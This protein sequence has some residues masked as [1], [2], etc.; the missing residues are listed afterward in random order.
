MGTT[1]T[2]YNGETTTVQDPASKSR[3]L[4]VD[5][6]G[7]ITSANAGSLSSAT[8]TYDSLGNAG[9]VTP[10]SQV[11]TFTYSSLSRLVSS[12]QPENGTTGYTFDDN[13]N[14]LKRTNGALKVFEFKPPTGAPF[15]KAY[16]GLNR[17]RRKTIQQPVGSDVDITWTWDT[18]ASNGKGQLASVVYGDTTISYGAYDSLGRVTSHTQTTAGIGY[19]FVYEYIR[20]DEVKKVTDPSGRA[21]NHT[22]DTAGRTETASA[23]ATSYAAAVTYAPHGA[24]R[25]MDIGGVNK[26]RASWSTMN[27]RL[28]LEQFT[29]SNLSPLTTLM[30]LGYSYGGTANNGNPATQTVN[31]GAATRTQNY[32]YDT[33]NRLDKACEA[34]SGVTGCTVNPAVT[35]NGAGY[36]QAYGYDAYGNRWIA[37]TGTVPT[38]ILQPT[39]AGAFDGSTNRFNAATFGGTYDGAGQMTAQSSALDPIIRADEKWD[40]AGQRVESKYT[41]SGVPYLNTMAYDALGNRVKKLNAWVGDTV[42]VSLCRSMR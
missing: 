1:V 25:Q 6:L 41:Y 11:R 17:P 14:L 21:V 13:G 18:V 24:V 28:Q 42:Y 7:W 30:S 29:V 40:A 5:A 33:A 31:D 3:T 4:T 9:S 36:G 2:S 20:N 26:L 32:V 15:E 34:N 23:G 16:D 8:N 27:G 38:L 19:P 35:W 12:T 10:G 39:S 37:P 22:L